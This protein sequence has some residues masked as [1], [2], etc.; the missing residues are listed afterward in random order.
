MTHY[1]ESLARDGRESLTLVNRGMAQAASGD[2]AGAV[3][4]WRRANELDPGDP[5]PLFNLGNID[6]LQS[7]FDAAIAR[8]RSA[9]ERDESLVP[10]NMNLA[11]AL[12]ASG[13]YQDA[14]RWVRRARR[15]D[16]S[17]ASGRLLEAQ[18]LD[19]L[20]RPTRR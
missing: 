8:Y 16:S 3:E 13:R 20:Q 6:L 19:M 12:A 4:S 7:R 18:L 11:R 9:V 5:L 2:T 15:F 17:D 10:A 1:D 14:L